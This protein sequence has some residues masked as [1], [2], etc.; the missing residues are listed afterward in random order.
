MPDWRGPVRTT[1][2]NSVTAFLRSGSNER[3]M[4]SEPITGYYAFEMHIVKRICVQD[5]G[6]IYLEAILSI[7]VRFPIEKG[8][9]NRSI[10]CRNG[11]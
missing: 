6:T 1:A 2:G 11:S 8:I 5:S 10:L 3:L 4:Y 9:G 7:P